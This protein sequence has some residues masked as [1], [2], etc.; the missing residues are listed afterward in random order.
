MAR[1]TTD[2]ALSRRA[3]VAE[4]ELRGTALSVIARELKSDTR[5]IRA[6]LAVLAQERAQDANLAG[7]RHRLL[8]AAKLV[9]HESW[10]LF[11]ALSG[12]DSNGK[13]GA[14][15]K[16]LAAQAQGAKVVGDLA[17]ADLERRLADLEQRLAVTDA[18][19]VRHR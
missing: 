11:H 15:S 10:S 16:V 17:A 4:L 5:T 19:P 1:A 6:D 12:A 14:L 18:G 8:A 7:E 2:Q 9:E 13:L 3:R